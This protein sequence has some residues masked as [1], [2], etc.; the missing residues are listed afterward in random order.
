M[1]RSDELCLHA[2]GQG[3]ETAERGFTLAEVLVALL[4]LSVGLLAVAQAAGTA[5]LMV[6]QSGH[7]AEVVAHAEE[8]LDSV[9]AAGYPSNPPGVVVDTIRIRDAA[10]VR[11]LTTT[12]DG[13]R[14][15]R[16]EVQVL[17]SDGRRGYSA[18]TYVLR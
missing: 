17:G 15:R 4:V 7:Y 9:R 18:L 14:S 3:R 1:F 2:P 16:I 6:R 8:A 13:M 11:R 10:Y 5:A 12:N